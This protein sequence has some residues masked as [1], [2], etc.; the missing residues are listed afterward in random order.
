MVKIYDSPCKD[1]Q[2][3]YVSIFSKEKSNTVYYT[4]D[5]KNSIRGFYCSPYQSRNIEV[6]SGSARVVVINFEKE[7]I[8][9][10]KEKE[11][12]NKK[13]SVKAGEAFGY[14]AYEDNTV[15][16]YITRSVYDKTE[17][18][19]FNP[20]Q[21][22]SELWNNESFN[23]KKDKYNIN[24]KDFNSRKNIDVQKYNIRHV[25]FKKEVGEIV[26]RN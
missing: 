21:N 7:E 19:I 20:I 1:N 8:L 24:S 26:K 2:E 13:I 9:V 14:I 12:E 23:I 5:E 17:E 18:E 6:V 22:C 15:I 25:D 16:K 10:C 11:N 3:F 4:E